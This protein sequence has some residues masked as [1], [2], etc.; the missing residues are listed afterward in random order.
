VRGADARVQ[1]LYPATRLVK[2][3]VLDAE[4]LAAEAKRLKEA[5]VAEAAAIRMAAQ[6]EADS[7]RRAAFEH[8]AKEAAGEFAAL[9]KKLEEE[10]EAMRKRFAT[11]V[12][13]VAFRFA[14]AVLDV[15]FA[16]R[17]ERLTQL[18]SKVMQPAR[19]YHRVKIHLHP[20]DVDR[21]KADQAQLVKQL[22]F[23]RDL[24]FCPADDLPP[25]G[26]RVETEMGSYDGNID[27]QIKKLQQHLL[28]NSEP[29]GDAT[30]AEE[31]PDGG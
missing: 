6:D 5:A 28:P 30:P 18:V 3:A 1:A 4:R 20:D 12:Q 22:A 15:E 23:V 29:F 27:T 13:R 25:H 10:I 31:A 11:D 2:G 8:G 16:A 17:P 9:L 26:V 19:L 14:R 21:V 7:V 24:Q